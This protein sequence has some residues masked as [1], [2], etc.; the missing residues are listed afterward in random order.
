MKLVL[1]RVLSARLTVG[2]EEISKIGNG[3]VVYFGAGRGD[4]ESDADIAVR[5]TANLRVFEKDGK[6]NLSALD[7]GAEILFVS[8]FTL[9]GDC[10]KGN[11]PSFTEAE[12]PTRANELYEYAASRLAETGL[13][14]KKGVF[15]ADMT[16]EQTNDGP[17]TI[18]FDT[19]A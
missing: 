9:Y 14:V 11:R 6:M 8:Q 7:S 2:G 15:G 16:I 10:R 1:Q 3:L 17:V 5:K 4:T 19:R 18:I 13:T 12:E